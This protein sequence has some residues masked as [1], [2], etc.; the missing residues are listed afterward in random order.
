MAETE[1]IAG[2]LDLL[3]LPLDRRQRLD[4]LAAM[5][6]QADWLTAEDVL[7][8]AALLDHAA[9]HRVDGRELPV[10]QVAEIQAAYI[11]ALEADPDP[12]VV[13][14]LDEALAVRER[15]AV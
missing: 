7:L 1:I 2:F 11:E 12:E 3:S 15:P 8:A 6:R 9:R 14:I 5:A 4:V 10:E 13:R